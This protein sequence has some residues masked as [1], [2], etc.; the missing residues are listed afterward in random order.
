MEQ[1]EHQYQR[2]AI[3]GDRHFILAN[4][5][6]PDCWAL[7][8]PVVMA[9]DANGVRDYG[10]ARTIS[11]ARLREWARMH[12]RSFAIIEDFP[13]VRRGFSDALAA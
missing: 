12:N 13:V 8:G 6:R 2:R 11:T 5:E 9:E 7:A 4:P 3:V 1:P 10:P